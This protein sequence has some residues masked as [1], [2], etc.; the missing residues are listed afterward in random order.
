MYDAAMLP[1]DDAVAVR[2][3][4]KAVIALLAVNAGVLALCAA[5]EPAVTA[6]WF[7]RFGLVP[8]VFLASLEGSPTWAWLSPTTAMFLHGDLLHFAGN[9]LFL[10]IFGPPVEER[11]GWQRFAIFYLTCGLAAGLVQV[12][13]TPGSFVPAIGASGAVSGLLGAYAVSQPTG[14]LSLAWS[15][16]RVPAIAFLFL[17]IVFQIGSDLGSPDDAASGIAG[18][19]HVGGFLAGAALARSTWVR[20]PTPSGH[21]I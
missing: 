2:P 9:A 10:W 14:R 21:G 4:P 16:V 17:W 7:E 20:R 1:L 11:L 12:A 15:P 18:W 19:A 8:R 13:A 3:A 5:G 6:T